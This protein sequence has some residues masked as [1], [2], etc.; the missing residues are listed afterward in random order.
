MSLSKKGRRKIYVENEEYYWI[1]KRVRFGKFSPFSEDIDI[2]ISLTIE[3]CE[4]RGRKICALF[5]AKVLFGFL[6]ADDEQTVSITPKI[7][8]HVIN[9]AQSQG[10]NPREIWNNLVI[11]SAEKVLKI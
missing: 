10:W 5:E 9:Y 11:Q 4:C 8:K 2:A 1:A 7:V 6:W 3:H